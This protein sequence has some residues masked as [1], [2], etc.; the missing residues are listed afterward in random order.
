MTVKLHVVPNTPGA[1]QKQ[2]RV[3]ISLKEK[4]YRILDRW[5]SRDIIE[6]VGDETDRLHSKSSVLRRTGTGKALG[7]VSR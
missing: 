7:Q 4:F 1:V 2:R 3:S 6:D 5:L